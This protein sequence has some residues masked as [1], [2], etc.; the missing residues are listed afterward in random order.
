[1]THNERVLE[2]LSDG[3]PHTHHEIYGLFV[4]GH[5]R[6]ADLRKRGHVI[7]SWRD[8]D[9]YMYQLCPETPDGG[10]SPPRDVVGALTPV[11]PPSGQLSLE[12]AA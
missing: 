1:V 8:G 3:K 12:A 5:S 4:I 7:E 10:V 6:I 11:A 2:L 9:D